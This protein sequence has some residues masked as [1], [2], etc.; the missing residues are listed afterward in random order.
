MRTS[1]RERKE[2]STMFDM[3]AKSVVEK[4][5]PI[6]DNFERG[7]AGLGEEQMAIHL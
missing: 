2:K 5:L 6:I 1:A 4:L 7:F 3:G